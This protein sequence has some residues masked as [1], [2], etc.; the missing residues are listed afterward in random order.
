[1]NEVLEIAIKASLSAGREIL[2]IYNN[3][4]EDFGIERKS[5]N[6]PLTKADKASHKIIMEALNPTNIP[7]LS[8]EGA[9]IPYSERKNWSKLWIVDPL[10]GT[11]EFIKK[12][13]GRFYLDLDEIKRERTSLPQEHYWWHR[14]DFLEVREQNH[15]FI[16]ANTESI[17]SKRAIRSNSSRISCFISRP[18]LIAAETLS[19]KCSASLMFEMG[20]MASLSNLP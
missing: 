8:E 17:F 11:K 1:M 16:S 10:D 4:A 3:P 20:I 18:T 9:K 6:S 2:K 19:A 5:D 15:K 13:G 12:N 14:E 7:I